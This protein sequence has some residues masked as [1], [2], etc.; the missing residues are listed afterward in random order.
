[1]EDTGCSHH[2]RIAVVSWWKCQGLYD[3]LLIH[4]HLNERGATSFVGVCYDNVTMLPDLGQDNIMPRTN[5]RVMRWSLHAFKE[6]HFFPCCSYGN[7]VLD[8]HRTTPR[9]FNKLSVSLCW[10]QNTL[11]QVDEEYIFLERNQHY[12]SR[13]MEGKWMGMLRDG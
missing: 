5:T 7:T 1:M 13:R 6:A 3:P 12:L 2:L 9:R 11:V 4:I 10:V 8:I